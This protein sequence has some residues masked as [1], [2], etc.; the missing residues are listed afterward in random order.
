MK[1][2]LSTYLFLMMALQ[3]FEAQELNVSLSKTNKECKLGSA[4][5]S[6]HSAALPYHVEWSNGAVSDEI[7]DLNSGDYSVYVRDDHD[8][9]TTI[10]FNIEE[11]VCEPV[12]SIYFSPNSD[13]LY[14]T[15]SISRINY[16]PDFELFV[17]N[18]WGQQVHHQEG[19]YS[20][21]DGTSLGLPLPDGAYY[22]ILFLSKSDKNKFVKG[23][24]SII[25]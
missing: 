20:P 5:V 8:N 21:W 17:Y 7:N 10:F 6:I 1:N 25:R 23:D 12:P 11:F 15:W 2:Y 24:V 3:N 22:Y 18:R 9:D 14:D 16:F 13:L 19:S 4:S